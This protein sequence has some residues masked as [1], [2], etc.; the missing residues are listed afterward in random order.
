MTTIGERI[1]QL[2]RARGLS[3]QE[4]A[5]QAEVSKGYIWGL[6]KGSSVRPS[7]AKLNSLAVALNG[8]ID[9]LWLAVHIHKTFSR[10]FGRCL[11]INMPI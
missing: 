8:S 6:E 9:Y 11:G 2:R 7:A 10:M 1:A 4:L 3:L 5:D